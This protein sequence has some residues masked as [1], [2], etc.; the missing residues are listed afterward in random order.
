MKFHKNEQNG[1]ELWAD[2]NILRKIA[3][4]VFETY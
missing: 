2:N 3:K 4:N 1:K